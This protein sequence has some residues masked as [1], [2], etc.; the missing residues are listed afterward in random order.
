[1]K[2]GSVLTSLMMQFIKDVE[3]IVEM[4]GRRSILQIEGTKPKSRAIFV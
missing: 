4:Q 2:R 3:Y 1:M